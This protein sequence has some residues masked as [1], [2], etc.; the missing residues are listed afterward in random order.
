MAMLKSTKAALMSAFIFPGAG[1]FIL[2]RKWV[3]AIAAVYCLMNLSVVFSI[4]YEAAEYRM[5]R[6]FLG[7]NSQSGNAQVDLFAALSSSDLQTAGAAMIL[8]SLM[9]AYSIYLSWYAG[10]L[11]EKS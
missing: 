8:F 10:R 2:N 5:D 3:G 11:M 4:F 9:W 1:F 7:L 6:L